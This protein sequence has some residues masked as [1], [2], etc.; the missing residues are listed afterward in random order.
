METDFEEE[1]QDPGVLGQ[2]LRTLL[3]MRLSR[4]WYHH[5]C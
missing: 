2:S 5:H 4:S 3:S 1:E